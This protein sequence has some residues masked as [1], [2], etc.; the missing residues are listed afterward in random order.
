MGRLLNDKAMNETPIVGR[1]YK[2][3]RDGKYLGIATFTD[4]PNNG[5]CFLRAVVTKSGE[6]AH[7]VYIADKWI[8][9]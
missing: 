1:D 6:L 5:L 8:K 2:L 7:E 4:D 3:W 9:V